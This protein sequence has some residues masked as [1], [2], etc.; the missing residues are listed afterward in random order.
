MKNE[1]PSREEFGKEKKDQLGVDFSMVWQVLVNACERG[2]FEQGEEG[3]I[4]Y[5]LRE[6]FDDPYA[7]DNPKYNEICKWLKQSG[8][9]EAMAKTS[10]IL[11]ELVSGNY[12]IFSNLPRL[13]GGEGSKQKPK[14]KKP[15]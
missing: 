6:F 7:L 15:K 2:H 12:D 9:S 13:G 1:V 5:G 11:H 10:K 14:R 4:L 8:M 3:L